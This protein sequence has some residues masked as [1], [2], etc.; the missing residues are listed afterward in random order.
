MKIETA[1]N[2]AAI[3]LLEKGDYLHGKSIQKG[4]GAPRKKKSFLGGQQGNAHSLAAP[5]CREH[6]S[7]ENPSSTSLATPSM[8]D[9]Y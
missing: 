5:D 3:G 2:R 4:T 6:E 8:R 1:R 9:S 7:G